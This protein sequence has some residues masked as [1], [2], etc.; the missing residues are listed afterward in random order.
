[1]KFKQSRVNDELLFLLQCGPRSPT[2]VQVSVRMLGCVCFSGNRDLER[3]SAVKK[4]NAWIC[5]LLTTDRDLDS[6]NTMK[7][8]IAWI[9]A[10]LTTD[11]DPASVIPDKKR[12]SVTTVIFHGPIVF[13]IDKSRNYF[14]CNSSF[15][16]TWF[17]E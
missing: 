1:M 14:F 17:F 5:A 12:T 15:L 8:V 11:R 6:S 13:G 7:R 3:V 10:L 2:R 16:T 4:V 9:C